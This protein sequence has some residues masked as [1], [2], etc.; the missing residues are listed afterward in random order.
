MVRLVFQ[1]GVVLLLWT[2]GGV[3]FAQDSGQSGDD[4]DSSRQTEQTDE[5]YRQQME[6]A[7]QDLAGRTTQDLAG[8]LSDHRLDRRRRESDSDRADLT[9]AR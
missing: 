4:D 5:S 9:S 8:E 2:G 1:F 6:L 3:L 7:Q